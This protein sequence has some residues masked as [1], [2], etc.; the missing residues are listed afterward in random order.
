MLIVQYAELDCNRKTESEFFAADE[1]GPTNY[2]TVFEQ[3]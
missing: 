3:H 1:K 2:P